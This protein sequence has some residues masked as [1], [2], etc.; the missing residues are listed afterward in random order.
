M[1]K[2]GLPVP[3]HPDIQPTV[4]HSPTRIPLAYCNGSFIT[5][6]EFSTPAAQKWPKPS[7]PLTFHTVVRSLVASI[8]DSSASGAMP[9]DPGLLNVMQRSAGATCVTSSDTRIHGCGK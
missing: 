8:A 1:K 9:D 5:F 3:R 6:D 4:H 2:I 7:H